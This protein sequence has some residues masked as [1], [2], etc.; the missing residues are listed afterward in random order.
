MRLAVAFVVL[1]PSVANAWQG[2]CR[3]AGGRTGMLSANDIAASVCDMDA[4]PECSEGLGYARGT[5]LGEHTYLTRE[6][7][8]LAGLS[9]TLRDAPVVFENPQ[10]GT[11][12]AL[13]RGY[14]TDGSMVGGVPTLAPAGA[15]SMRAWLDRQVA[16]AELSEVADGS[17][18]I[19]EYVMGNEHCLP[20]GVPRETVEDVNRCHGFAAHMGTINSSHWPEQAE[21]YYRLYHQ[22]AL[23]TA[24]RCKQLSDARA[25][26]AEHPLYDFTG[27]VVV[28]CEREALAYQA[29]ASHY[30]EDAWSTGH[31]FRRW[32]QPTFARSAVGLVQQSVVSLVVGMIHG[33]RAVTN[34]HDQL[35]MPGPFYTDDRSSMVR[36]R[37]RDRSS[38]PGGGDLYLLPCRERDQGWNVA[39]GTELASQRSQMSSCL[40]HG[41][42]EVYAA[43]PKTQGELPLDPALAEPTVTDY[44]TSSRCWDQ[45]VTNHSMAMGL[46]SSARLLGFIPASADIEDYADPSWLVRFGLSYAVDGALEERALPVTDAEVELESVRMRHVLANLALTYTRVARRRPSGDELAKMIHQSGLPNEELRG[47]FGTPVTQWSGANVDAIDDDRIAFLEDR[48]VGTW[49][50]IPVGEEMCGSDDGCPDGT[51][52]DVTAV[53]ELGVVEP[54]CV[55]HEAPI[56]R[57]FRSAQLAT[58]CGAERWESLNAA[59]DACE[60]SAAATS[61][62]CD[63]CVQLV[64]P[65]LRNACEPGAIPRLEMEGRDPRSLC[66]ILRDADG[67]DA[68]PGNNHYVH[69]PYEPEGTERGIDALARAAREACRAGAQPFP[70][71]LGLMYD[72]DYP[73]EAQNVGD[74]VLTYYFEAG[75]CGNDGEFYFRFVHVVGSPHTL[76]VELR[77]VEDAGFPNNANVEEF[78]LVAYQGPACDGAV[79]FTG[80]ASDTDDDGVNDLN[81]FTWEASGLVAEEICV[82]VAAKKPW[83]RAR[84]GLGV[85]R[86]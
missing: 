19:A 17:H 56:L 35:N 24:R 42:R 54:R 69:W 40:A 79:L 59:R 48:D 72:E 43:G 74:G 80:T 6:G 21:A 71:R 44:S 55:P 14:Y 65:R 31:M 81:A 53:S 18:S 82:R 39:E 68:T 52:C 32:G 47:V 46:G 70:F 83:A 78:E 45:W 9:T 11:A 1:L 23:T 4:P 7:M 28:A 76:G 25:S 73:D 75:M 5:Q 57:A 85:N 66:E 8:R 67:A 13:P 51:H 38:I 27:D 50:E 37:Q 2:V 15:G 29:Y 33:T 10:I 64:A 22:L 60:A 3:E 30:L 49:R 41:F 26:V 63:A 58:W 34:T 16:I 62:E 36:F 12:R 61:V 77:V 20:R 84:L 86:R